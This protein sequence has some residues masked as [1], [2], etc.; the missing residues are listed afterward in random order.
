MRFY[1]HAAEIF[2]HGSPTAQRSTSMLI[3]RLWRPPGMDLLGP[4]SY[5]DFF[6]PL[7][8]AE[9]YVESLLAVDRIVSRL[10]GLGEISVMADYLRGTG[11]LRGLSRPKVAS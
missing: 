6:R 10:P 2:L 5:A 11:F 8:S 1:H 3:R 7:L 9:K 4:K